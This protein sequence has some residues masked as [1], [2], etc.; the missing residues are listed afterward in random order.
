MLVQGHIT[1]EIPMQLEHIR[2]VE[3]S[4]GVVANC[5]AAAQT[6]KGPVRTISSLLHLILVRTEYA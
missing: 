3:A 1:Q 6:K 4:T 2:L 5:L